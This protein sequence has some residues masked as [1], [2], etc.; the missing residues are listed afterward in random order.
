MIY[1]SLMCLNSNI[2]YMNGLNNNSMD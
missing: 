2:S 1:E